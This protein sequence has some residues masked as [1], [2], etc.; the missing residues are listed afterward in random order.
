MG[1]VEVDQEHIYLA[2]QRTT[3]PEMDQGTETQG[4]AETGVT[5]MP[6]EVL[7]ILY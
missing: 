6:R 7:L 4:K 5:I 2:E 1:D 3:R